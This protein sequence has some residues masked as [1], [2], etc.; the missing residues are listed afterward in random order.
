MNA[1]VVQ[2]KKPNLKRKSSKR[3]KHQTLRKML[4]GKNKRVIKLLMCDK[5]KHFA[6]NCIH[7]KDPKEE[8]S[9]LKL[10][11]MLL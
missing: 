6:K 4:H 7:K 10:Q 1:N 3:V 11:L 2:S 8:K 9:V 5:I